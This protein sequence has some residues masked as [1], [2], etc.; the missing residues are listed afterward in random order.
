[1]WITYVSVLISRF[2]IVSL[3]TIAIRIGSL[4]VSLNSR[5]YKAYNKA[6]RKIEAPIR[7]WLFGTGKTCHL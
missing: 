5:V 6:N 1:M 2:A 4:E 3:L 7:H